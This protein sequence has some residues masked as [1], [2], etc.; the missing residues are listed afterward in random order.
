MFE[1]WEINNNPIIPPI[2]S[3]GLRINV[4]FKKGTIAETQP[5]LSFN[6][7]IFSNSGV[8]EIQKALENNGAYQQILTNFR[9][10]NRQLFKGYLTDIKFKL[11][12][13][14]IEA[15]PV[16]LDSTD[17][18]AEILSAMESSLLKDDYRYSNFEFRVEKVDIKAEL[19]QL[20][21]SILFYLYVLY[22]QIKEIAK[23]IARAIEAVTN[24][25]PPGLSFGTILALVLEGIALLIFL[26]STIVQLIKFSKQAKELL[27][28]RKRKTRVVTLYELIRAPLARAGYSLET[29]FED[30]K[31]EAHWASGDVNKSE[32]YP[33]SRDRCGNALGALNFVIDKYAA[34]VL[35]R[36]KT[37]YIFSR[38]SNRFIKNNNFKLGNFIKG[39]YTENTDDMP[40]TREILYSVDYDD[41]WT[42]ENF[43]GTEYKIRANIADPTKSVI[44]GLE[45]TDYGV[46]LCNRKDKL[47][48]IEKLWSDFARIVNSVV[49]LF[50]GKSQK[51][52]LSNSIGLGKVGSENM[53]VA[54]LVRLEGSRLPANHRQLLSAK[55]DEEN[56]HWVKSHVRNPRAKKKIFTEIPHV[57]NDNSLSFNLES[58]FLTT[59]DGEEGELIEVDWEY[60]K[61]NAVMTFEIEDIKRETKLI[62]TFFEPIK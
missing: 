22:T 50:G 51:L 39:N 17:G 26:A 49:S 23:F 7:L 35:V 11:D 44:K 16:S 37:V 2:E 6:N 42:L 52:G 56:Y 31:L 3:Q 55:S 15:K 20:Q 54:K 19:L 25:A 43:T 34:R 8:S 28:P 45:Q 24:A 61:D 18:L 62:E 33:R 46:S 36:D 13:D 21:L 47:N 57:Y 30:M 41:P 27:I 60:N 10:S 48:D 14:Q 58:S 40:G 32:H 29:E 53:S 1:D 12:T 38:N 4:A 59:Q 5:I 9:F